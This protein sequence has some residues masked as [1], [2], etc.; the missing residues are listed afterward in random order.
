M[1]WEICAPKHVDGAEVPWWM[2]QTTRLVATIYR[3]FVKENFTN[4]LLTKHV[5]LCKRCVA[6]LVDY[7]QVSWWVTQRQ[8]TRHVATSYQRFV[9]ENFTHAQLTKHVIRWERCVASLVDYVQMSRWMTLRQ[10]TRYV[11]IRIRT[12][13]NENAISVKWKWHVNRWKNCVRKRV[14]FVRNKDHFDRTLIL[15]LHQVQSITREPLT[16]KMFLNKRPYD[17]II[18]LSYWI[19]YVNLFVG[20]S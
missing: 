16:S 4:V 2:T 12:F 5:K 13:V 14:E 8:V 6:S 15:V 20:Y 11:A 7:V 10:M 17:T 3:H 18:Y 1:G 9:N 19:S